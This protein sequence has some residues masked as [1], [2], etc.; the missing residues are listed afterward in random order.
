MCPAL[1]VIPSTA[2]PPPAA[3]WQPP[4]RPASG[5]RSWC[6]F[7]AFRDRWG[8]I[9]RWTV[10]VLSS[11]T[12]SR[13]TEATNGWERHRRWIGTS[14]S[15]A[16]PNRKPK[17]ARTNAT[18]PRIRTSWTSKCRGPSRSHGTRVSSNDD[19]NSCNSRKTHL[20]NDTL[21]KPTLKHH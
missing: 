2:A 7:P 4:R 6:T 12:T 3:R 13:K 8:P 14:I 21:R 9:R 17:V 10:A 18:G 11:T 5:S 16:L 20:F 19:G 1:Q 15:P